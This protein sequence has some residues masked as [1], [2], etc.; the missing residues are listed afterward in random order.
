MSK[1][2]GPDGKGRKIGRGTVQLMATLSHYSFR[3]RLLQKAARTPEC[4]V[5]ICG[6]A[7]TSKTCGRCGKINPKLGSSER[8]RCTCGASLDRD[9]NAA[10]NILLRNLHSV[11]AAQ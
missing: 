6:E 3:T 1:K 5:L 8:F 4:S 7:Y 2:K 9:V 11:E 10:R